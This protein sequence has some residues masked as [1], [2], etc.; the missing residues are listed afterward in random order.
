VL[1]PHETRLDFSPEQ[2]VA[3]SSPAVRTTNARPTPSK[4]S[5]MSY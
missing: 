4:K 5:R 2:E 1:N 3:G